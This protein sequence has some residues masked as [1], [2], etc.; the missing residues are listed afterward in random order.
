MSAES[1]PDLEKSDHVEASGKLSETDVVPS[2]EVSGVMT[3]GKEVDSDSKAKKIKLVEW[4][5][6]D[7]PQ[8][9]QNWS[10]IR[11]WCLVTLISAV[12]FNR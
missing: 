1:P 3:A 5:S 2:S 12:T 6:P 4:D 10:G 11:K 9:P 7:D 8:N